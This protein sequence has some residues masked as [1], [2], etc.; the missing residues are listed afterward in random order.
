MLKEHI[1]SVQ[2]IHQGIKEERRCPKSFYKI[3]SINWKPT[4][5]KDCMR[6]IN[7]KPISHIS[8]KENKQTNK[9]LNPSCIKKKIYQFFGRII[10]EIKEWL[11]INIPLTCT[12][13]YLIV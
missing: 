3:F 1:I 12:L 9:K 2:K 11:K 8:V 4:S 10:R 7:H 6:K 13:T 5:E